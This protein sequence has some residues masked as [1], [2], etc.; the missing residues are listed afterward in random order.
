MWTSSFSCTYTAHD[1]YAHC[2]TRQLG[3]ILLHKTW[4][5]PGI[6]GTPSPARAVSDAE[7]EE[8]KASSRAYDVPSKVSQ[9]AAQHM[10]QV[11]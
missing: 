11:W 4:N 7:E 1:V 6:A 10:F 9:Q 3:T 8:W 2:I 5:W